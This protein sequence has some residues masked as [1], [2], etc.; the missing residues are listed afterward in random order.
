MTVVTPCG[1]GGKP[2]SAVAANARRS[3]KKTFMPG[4]CEREQSKDEEL[5]VQDLRKSQK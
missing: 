2:P 1:L 4:R 5:R 3:A